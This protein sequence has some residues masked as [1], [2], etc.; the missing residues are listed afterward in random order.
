M[1]TVIVRT[2]KNA[3]SK[4]RKDPEEGGNKYRNHTPERTYA[5]IVREFLYTSYHCQRHAMHLCG[6]L[7][8]LSHSLSVYPT[9][10]IKK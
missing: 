9:Y 5:F 10:A 4:A 8:S 3:C 1:C 2:N 6:K 7:D